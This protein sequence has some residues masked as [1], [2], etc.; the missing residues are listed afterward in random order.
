VS[1]TPDIGDLEAHLA[2]L[3]A[4][5]RA[6]ALA[7]LDEVRERIWREGAIFDVTA[8]AVP[9]LV[10]RAR[11]PACLVRP[12]ILQLLAFLYGG[13]GPTLVG[14]RSGDGSAAGAAIQTRLGIERAWVEATRAAVRRP[15]FDY[16]AL[17]ADEDR[18]VRIAAA[19]LLTVFHDPDAEPEVRRALSRRY[20]DEPDEV[21]RAT[22]LGSLNVYLPTTHLELY[23]QALERDVALLVRR[24]A[25]HSLA[26]VQ[27]EEASQLVAATLLEAILRAPELAPLYEGVAWSRRGVVADS[28][29]AITRL[30]AQARGLLRYLEKLMRRVA[31][32]DALHVAEAALLIAFE[33]PAGA[34]S[35][36]DLDGAQRSLLAALADTDAIW[37]HELPQMLAHYGLPREQEALRA[38]LA[39]S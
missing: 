7:A 18:D 39:R 15:L 37:G 11:D 22:V 30:G 34:R 23:E 20:A 1:P 25:A 13:E 17:L 10:E 27:R 12:P 21:V 2:R 24:E 5:E 14:L 33:G 35:L 3:A 6:A 32:R 8:A 9:A 4:S 29:W 28:L 38:Y 26:A 36:A 16:L 19:C 31:P